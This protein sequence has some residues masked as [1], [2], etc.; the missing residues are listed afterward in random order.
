MV[1]NVIFLKKRG[2]LSLE[3]DSVVGNH[4]MWQAVLS[5]DE[6]FQE[7]GHFLG[8][9]TGERFG[10]DPFREVVDGYDYELMTIG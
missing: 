8:G 5:E 7:L 1:L 6:L 10:L 3:L 9:N 2:C 4:V